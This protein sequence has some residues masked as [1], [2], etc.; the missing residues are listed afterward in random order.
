MSCFV[1]DCVVP[2]AT[3][4]TVCSK[5]SCRIS[6]ELMDPGDIISN[7][8]LRDFTCS[9]LIPDLAVHAVSS[10]RWNLIFLPAPVYFS[11]TPQ[12]SL[13]NVAT[14]VQSR[15]DEIIGT[16]I[17][18]TTNKDK[19]LHDLLGDDGYVFIK[20]TMMSFSDL[21]YMPEVSI[22]T[23]T[24]QDKNLLEIKVYK[25]ENAG[26]KPF[27]PKRYM[28][29]GS[30]VENWYSIIRNGL[31]NMSGSVW[32]INGRARGDGIY[33]GHDA[34]T[35]M[36]YTSDPIRIV[37]VLESSTD[38][39]VFNKGPAYVFP[40]ADFL[41]ISYLIVCSERATYRQLENS[42]TYCESLLRSF[43]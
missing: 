11:K 3:R 17:D 42:F 15:F 33:C 43:S 34:I 23:A 22:S 26:F 16:L 5:R 29:H 35:S 18:E 14:I 27:R 36:S 40:N 25:M 4:T 6:L 28:F 38:T 9:K 7:K 39:S 24:A 41:H 1:C 37:A 19:S 30:R 8:I 32:Q 10:D 2:D 13:M 21:E 12:P 20:F 31:K